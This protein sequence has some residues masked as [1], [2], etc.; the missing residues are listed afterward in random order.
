MA[1]KRATLKV[2]TSID[3]AAKT[4][5]LAEKKGKAPLVDDRRPS[6]TRPSTAKDNAKTIRLCQ[7]VL[8][9]PATL[10]EYAMYPCQASPLE[11]EDIVEDSEILGIS[12]ED[13]LKL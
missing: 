1:P 10:R 13:Q 6:T 4:A 5:L 7:R 8:L 9:A 11:A 12:A 2:V 3:N